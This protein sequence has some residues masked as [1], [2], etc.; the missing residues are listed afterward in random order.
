MQLVVDYVFDVRLRSLLDHYDFYV[1]PC[2]NPDGY[3]YSH[4]TVCHCAVLPFVLCLIS[5]CG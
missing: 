1:M 2:I 3:E 4:S 5:Q